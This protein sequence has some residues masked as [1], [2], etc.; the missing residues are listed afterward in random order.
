MRSRFPAVA[1]AVMCVC[2]VPSWAE[3]DDLALCRGIADRLR[4][5]HDFVAGATKLSPFDVLTK[6]AHP[7]V[8]I[9][10]RSDGVDPQDDPDAFLAKVQ[11]QFGLTPAVV[12]QL[13]K[14]LND[15]DQVAALD[16]SDLHVLVDTG[17]TAHCENF[18]FFNAT[19]ILPDDPVQT[20]DGDFRF[21]WNDGGDLA[22]VNGTAAF[23]ETTAPTTDVSW[24]FTVTPW[25]GIA[26]GRA[27]VAQVSIVTRYRLAQSYVPL[28][29][30]LP[31]AALEALVL[32]VAKTWDAT[33]N[34]KGFHF[35][36]A[37]P[38]RQRGAAARM[39]ALAPPDDNVSVPSFGAAR[40]ALAP[41]YEELDHSDVQP[42]MLGG[43]LY[44][45]RIGHATIGWRSYP[46]LVLILYT[47]K[48]DALAPVASVVIE[49]TAGALAGIT[50]A[51]AAGR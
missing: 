21:C 37:I 30:P 23:V 33:D 35:G 25:R 42:L 18:T 36:A 15:Y 10:P 45:L 5:H 43:R 34:G 26:W 11:K 40:N 29:A 9:A 13:R 1:M 2:L 14:N 46:D 24:A 39:V 3:G 20:H 48:D 50:V 8:A 41:Y 28:D 4:S 22:R 27:C 47:L 17:G 38:A 32:P 12:A 6:G 31:K 19:R 16:G 7:Y 44:L 51:R 49:K